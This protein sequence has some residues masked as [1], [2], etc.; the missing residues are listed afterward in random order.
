[1]SVVLNRT[2]VSGGSRG[3]Q[4]PLIFFKTGPTLI[5]GTG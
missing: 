2:V 1:M 5:L 3:A 4:P